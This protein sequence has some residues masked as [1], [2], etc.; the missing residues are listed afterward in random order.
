MDIKEGMTGLIRPGVG[1][2]SDS[3]VIGQ[4]I[5]EQ[6][7][8]DITDGPEDLS[9]FFFPW[10]AWRGG[11]QRFSVRLEPGTRYSA[12]SV[13]FVDPYW[14]DQPITLDVLGRSWK[15]FRESYDENR[16]KGAFEFEQRLGD[17]WRRSIGFR[18]ENVRVSDLDFDAPQEI[19]D[20]QGDSQLYGVKFGVGKTTVD[21]L[22]DPT[23]GWLANASYE[24]VT[25]D[26][27]FGLLEGSYI[28]Y[29]TV[30]ED[31][32]GR[33]T[34]LSARVRAA[35]TVGDAP[36]FEKFYA[37]GTGHYGIRGFEYRGVSTRG[38]QTNV[39]N[40]QRKDPIGSDWIFLAGTELL[41]PLFGQ[42][43][44]A[45]F[46]LDSGTVDTGSYRLS[47][48]AGIEI[49]VPQIFGHMPMRFELGFP[50]LKSEGD[51]TQVFSFSGGGFF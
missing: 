44:N 35:T 18:A 1:F 13:N 4:L 49:K 19:R 37:G 29:F 9:E 42:N 47:I 25:G 40:P 22:Y 16:L 45:L 17:Y 14:N 21:D 51:E 24:Q 48:G 5:Y 46:F 30:H 6:R 39:A 41:V 12:Y 34:T 11:G 15:W 38:F 27:T 43:F 50:L 32:L 8:F 36:P 20:V 31:V 33:R 7:N 10:K 26:F 28:H 3:G 2:S 23:A